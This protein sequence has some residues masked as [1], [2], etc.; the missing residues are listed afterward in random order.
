ME[1][2]FAATSVKPENETIL[3]LEYS[4]SPGFHLITT[5]TDLE[6]RDFRAN[7]SKNI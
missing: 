2:F 4:R 7:I 6:G 5:N 1:T 3:N